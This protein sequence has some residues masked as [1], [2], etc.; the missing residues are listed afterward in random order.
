MPETITP[1]LLYE[2]CAGAL[3]WLSKAFGFNERLRFTDDE[4]N[5]THAEMELGG[6][7]VM[8]GDPG[9]RYRN[10]SQVGV[11]VGIHVYVDDVDAHFE[12]AK[13]ADAAIDEEPTDQEYGDRRYSAKDPEGHQWYFAQRIRELA[14]E[15]WGATTSGAPAA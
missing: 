14:P 7:S 3:D 6:G 15:D 2:D 10:P 1:Y 5:V 11:T 9:S 12:R 4:G 8:M 13:A